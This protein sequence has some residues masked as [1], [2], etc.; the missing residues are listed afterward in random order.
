MVHGRSLVSLFVPFALAAFCVSLPAQKVEWWSED[1]DS[2]L[3]ASEF[4]DAGMLLLYFWVQD[5]PDCS[6]MFSGTMSE[7]KVQAALTG[8]VCMGAQRATDAGDELFG[9]FRIE[10]SPTILFLT[11]DGSVVDVIVGYLPVDGLLAELGRIK[12]GEGTVLALREATAKAP[13]DLALQLELMRKL[14]ATGDQKGSHE[15]IDAIVAKDP[16]CKRE[17]AAEAMLVRLTDQVFPPDSTPQSW[18]LEPLYAFLRQQKHKRILF[19]GY[20]RLADGAYQQEDLKAWAKY[21]ERAWKSV[22]KDRV[23]TWGQD[24]AT[25]VC[26]HG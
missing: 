9:R 3:D 1:F 23:Q 18:D 11:P 4:A 6:A 24:H 12:K 20:S 2:A 15:V 26:K 13:D 10:R 5:N 7:E 25:I 16:K 17:P 19:L 21:A 22:P 8:F 14:R